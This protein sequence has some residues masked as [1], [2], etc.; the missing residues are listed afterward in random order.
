MA[1]RAEPPKPHAR[2]ID[3][4]F[5]MS[6]KLTFLGTCGYVEHRTRR[7]RRH[8]ALLVCA[9]AGPVMVDCGLDWLGRVEALAPRAIL[10]THAHP[11]HA[12]G[13][14]DGAPCPVL[15]TAE[16]LDALADYPLRERRPLV[17]RTRTR[18]AGV[19][20]EAFP[21]IH[22]L[23]APAVGFRIAARGHSF[24]YVPDVVAILDREAAL[25]GIELFV[26]DAATMTRPMVRRQGNRLFGHTTVRAQIGWCGK[27]GVRQAVFTHCGSE[28]I[29]GDERHLAAKLRAMGR[30]R[31]VEARFAYDG[32]ELVLG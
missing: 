22:S 13:L 25:S 15:A 7:H 6:L 11:D 10:V 3:R 20:V 31:G 12:W 19:T 14:R 8:S 23:R 27:A 4:L 21:V 2:I 32:L 24:F 9:G 18:V 28:I 5:A 29:E 17:P 26:G 16:C 30:Q 1:R